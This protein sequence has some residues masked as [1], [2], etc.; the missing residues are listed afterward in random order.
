MASEVELQRMAQ[1]AQS[2]FFLKMLAGKLHEGWEML[3]ESYPSIRP[4]ERRDRPLPNKL[5]PK[6]YYDF[7]PDE[8]K[9]GLDNL[10]KYFNKKTNFIFML[11]NKYAF[12]YDKK[13]VANEIDNISEEDIFTILV[14]EARGNSLSGFSDTIIIS[15]IL[16]LIDKNDI[17]KAMDGLYKEIVSTADLLLD[18]GHHVI[19]LIVDK[20]E[21]EPT[22][23]EIDL[24]DVAIMEDI[25][26]PFFIG[27]REQLSS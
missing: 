13:K 14:T 9:N 23:T 18:F 20:L 10:I 12:H 19:A 5:L 11:R 25:R 15:S 6:R 16:R 21:P 17:Q 22:S 2:L 27:R 4:A 24:Q 3:K 26:L 7:L 1:R 8:V